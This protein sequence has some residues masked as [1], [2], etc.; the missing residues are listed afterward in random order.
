MN[1][2]Q[3]P[4]APNNNGATPIFVAAQENHIEVMKLLMNAT[5]NPNAPRNNRNTP[6]FMAALKN[7]LEIVQLLFAACFNIFFKGK[8]LLF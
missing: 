5:D 6:I 7:N 2:A 8:R 1:I 4:N 3:N